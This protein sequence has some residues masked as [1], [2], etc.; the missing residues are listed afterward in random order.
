[1][2]FQVPQS[3]KS[4]RQNR[5]EFDID[6]TTYSIPLLK[7]APVE[8]AE[9]FENDKP[10]RALMLA[11]NDKAAADI[12]RSLDGEQFQALMDAWTE[13][14]DVTPGESPASTGSSASTETPSAATSSA[15]ASASTTSAPTS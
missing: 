6:G 8:A 9:A 3:K 13:A 11:A 7:Y 2:P 4:I 12:I 15:P 5:F 10:I 14:S 1:M